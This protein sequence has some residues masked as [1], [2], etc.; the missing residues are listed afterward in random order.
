VTQDERRA[1]LAAIAERNRASFDEVRDYY[2]EQDLVPQ[3]AMEIAERKVRT[4]LRDSAR[5]SPGA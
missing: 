1:E 3:L 5:I 4:F 2:Q